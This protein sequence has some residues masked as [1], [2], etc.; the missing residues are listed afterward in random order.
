MA[1]AIV[2]RQGMGEGRLMNL[3][4]ATRDKLSVVAVTLFF[5]NEKKERT[6]RA[7]C[8]NLLVI[9]GDSDDLCGALQKR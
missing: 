5:G 7:E 6:K 4:S 3:I 1:T 2:K 9:C 8:A